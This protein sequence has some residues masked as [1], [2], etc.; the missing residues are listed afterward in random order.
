M[1]AWLLWLVFCAFSSSSLFYFFGW[2]SSSS[3]SCCWFSSL[4]FSSSLFSFVIFFL[5]FCFVLF[6]SFL[7]FCS[8][9]SSLSCFLFHCHCFFPPFFTSCIFPS[10]S[11]HSLEA[12]KKNGPIYLPFLAV[13]LSF[14]FGSTT[15]RSCHRSPHS[16]PR[17]QYIGGSSGVVHL[18]IH[19]IHPLKFKRASINIITKAASALLTGSAPTSGRLCCSAPRVAAAAAARRPPPT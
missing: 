8:S 15:H 12:R 3:S 4:S 9:S 13:S 7:Y 16:L 11:K 2:F 17:A 18:N 19:T 6:L 14:N 1:C 10:S 5:V